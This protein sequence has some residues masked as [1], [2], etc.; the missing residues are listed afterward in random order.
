MKRA[1]D[2]IKELDEGKTIS[3]QDAE[4]ILAPLMG[5]LKAASVFASYLY[6]ADKTLL[7]SRPAD[8]LAMYDN[9]V[10]AITTFSDKPWERSDAQLDA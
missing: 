2:V 6:R 9:I 10:K 3:G 8:E 7:A 5:V 4:L 1:V